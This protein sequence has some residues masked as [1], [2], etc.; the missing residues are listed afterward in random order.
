VLAS[1]RA[2][3]RVL[4]IVAGTAFGLLGISVYLPFLERVFR[5]SP[6]SAGDALLALAAGCATLLWLEA[7]KP[8]WNN[9]KTGQSNAG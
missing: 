9:K 1:L 6:L 2:P 8:A 5:F 3:N 4:W 7:I